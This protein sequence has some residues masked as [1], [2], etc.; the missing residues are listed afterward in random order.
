MPK[1]IAAIARLAALA[2]LACG[3]VLGTRPDTPRAATATTVIVAAGKPTEFEFRLSRVTVPIGAVTFKVT[4]LGEKSHDFKILDT[5]TKRL[6]PGQS[7]S[8]TVIFTK[9]GKHP[10]FCTVAGHAA[11][12]MKGMLT[13][14]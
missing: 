14:K 7:Q 12:G 2:A 8:I 1:T 6:A 10:F 9:A 5:K 11:A 3:L 4:N 13:V